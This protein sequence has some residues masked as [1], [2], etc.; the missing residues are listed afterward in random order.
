MKIRIRRE[1]CHIILEKHAED[2]Q[3]GTTR[4]FLRENLE[5]ELERERAEILRKAA[6]TIQRNVR[7]FL[8]QKRYQNAKQSAIKIQS[9]V[10]GWKERK[11]YVVLRKGV[12]KTQALYRGRKQRQR[13]NQLKVSVLVLRCV[14]LCGNYFI[15]FFRFS[16]V[17][18]KN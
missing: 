2:Y 12:I 6:M 11:K 9:A 10:R 17:N 16:T 4:V 7:G 14:N 3:L 1:L 13:Y 5:R 18:R 15:L 8:A